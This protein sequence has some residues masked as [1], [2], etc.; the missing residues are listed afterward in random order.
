MKKGIFKIMFGIVAIA[1]THIAAAQ[2]VRPTLEWT[3][4][5]SSNTTIGFTTTPITVNFLRDLQNPLIPTNAPTYTFDPTP[6]VAT[7]SLDKQQR[8]TTLTG[9]STVVP[10]LTFGGRTTSDRHNGGPSE[11]PS[12][13]GVQRLGGTNVYNVFAADI[14]ASKPQNN[15]FIT[16]PTAPAAATTSTTGGGSGLTAGGFDTQNISGAQGPNAIDVGGVFAGDEDANFGVALYTAS[17]PLADVLANPAGRFYYGDVVI[18]FNR[19]VK[20]PVIHVGGLGG[21]YKYTNTSGVELNSFFTTELELATT[22]AS[23]ASSLL[24]GNL[25]IDVLNNNISNTNAT[26]NGGSVLGDASYGAASGSIKVT[27]TFTQLVYRVYLKG[28]ATSFGWSQ[29]ASNITS[30]TRDPFNGDLWYLSVSLEKPTQQLSGNVFIDKDGLKDA[31]GGDINKSAGVAN[32][33]TNVGN[34]LFANLIDAAVGSPTFGKVV[35][36]TPVGTDGSYLFDNIAVGSYTVQ[37]TTIQGV[38]NQNPPATTLPP[39]W[40]NTG[41]FVGSGVGSDGTINGNSAVVVVNSE[42]IKT[43]VNFGINRLPESIS[44]STAISTPSVGNVFTLN[45]QGPRFL[46]ILSGSDPEDQ[47]TTA[48]LTTRSLVITTIPTNTVLLYNGSPVTAGQIINGFNPA[49]LQILFNQPI[50]GNGGSTQFSY[51]TIDAAGFQDPTPAIY[52]VSWPEGAVPIVLESFDAFKNNCEASIVW[53][54]SSEI[55]ADKYEVEVSTNAGAT[56][57]AFA[58]LAARG[59]NASAQSYQ[60]PFAMQS[61]IVYVFRLKSIDKDGSFTYS[62][63]RKLSCEGKNVITIAPNPVVDIFRISGMA[64]GRNIVNMYS[65]DG[66]LIKTQV[67]ANTF[68]DVNVNGLAAGTYILN[69]INENGTAQSE[70]IIKR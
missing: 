37:L 58:T 46:P 42:N 13:I 30:A 1:T 41:E 40:V 44:F 48:V 39:N 38:I 70:R 50:P 67:I 17:E 3:K 22:A 28:S 19:P 66:K 57:K 27:G 10:G 45:N 4:D 6:L 29:T 43:E 8:S 14:P 32:V 69:V 64:N 63:V 68:G 12:A 55:N 9:T 36:V 60:T 62:G 33:K 35:G 56:Y 2:Q 26:P 52:V 49:L 18:N 53:K 51:A 25:N 15:M 65:A 24:A 16:S 61:G 7:I 47:P 54:T 31:G 59:T 21:S 5:G 11:F 23:N 20:N 34:L